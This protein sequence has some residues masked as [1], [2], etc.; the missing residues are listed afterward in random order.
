MPEPREPEKN[1]NG[2]QI[3]EPD[4]PVDFEA[5]LKI[6]EGDE[7]ELL[8]A[9]EKEINRIKIESEE[10]EKQMKKDFSEGKQKELECYLP[11]SSFNF[12]IKINSEILDAS[13]HLSD[14]L[15][16]LLSLEDLTEGGREA[17][18]LVKEEYDKLVEKLK[19]KY[20]S[21]KLDLEMNKNMEKLEESFVL[22][23][24]KPK[25]P[26]IYGNEELKK[27][28]GDAEEILNNTSILGKNED[29]KPEPEL[30]S[31]LKL[32]IDETKSGAEIE[33][34]FRKQCSDLKIFGV[35]LFTGD[36][37]DGWIKIIG[38]DKKSKEAK[39]KVRGSKIPQKISIQELNEKL[40]KYNITEEE[41][42]KKK[43]LITKEYYEEKL[44]K[45]ENYFLTKVSG[46]KSEWIRI[47]GYFEGRGIRVLEGSG[48][49]K[50]VEKRKISQ[51]RFVTKVEEIE[52]LMRGFKKE[53]WPI[54]SERLNRDE[55]DGYCSASEEFMAMRE[56]GLTGDSTFNSL[57]EE[58]KRTRLLKDLRIALEAQLLLR[59]GNFFQIKETVE[60]IIEKIT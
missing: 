12:Q 47:D 6:K 7:D 60:K 55:F 14:D 25:D 24:E 28:F 44:K 20:E 56:K 10:K 1:V 51:G 31:I 36:R 35:E 30:E 15:S 40:E 53:R 34:E 42:E 46:K 52:K 17:V 2:Q 16:D 21:L 50:E 37:H 41:M 45:Y 38:F 26:N 54:Y 27:S 4:K 9:A 59:K 8:E 39:I 23:G 22:E 5:V 58:E 13:I 33:A 57:S 3:K 11:N 49:N 19:N 43:E 29:T 32:N 48:S 18:K